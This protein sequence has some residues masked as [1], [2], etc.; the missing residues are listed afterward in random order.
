MYYPRKVYFLF[1]VVETVLEVGG[2]VILNLLPFMTIFLE[3]AV[4]TTILPG[5]FCL[6]ELQAIGITH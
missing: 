4:L 3:V 1:S 6:H 5:Y 2:L